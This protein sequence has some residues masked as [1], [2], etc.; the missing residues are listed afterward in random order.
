VLRLAVNDPHMVSP[1]VLGGVILIADAA[2]VADDG[3]TLWQNGET[4]A[5]RGVSGAPGPWTLLLA[6]F[7]QFLSLE[8]PYPPLLMVAPSRCVT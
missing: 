6:A 1:P 5:G 7:G 8:G 4:P 3:D 2:K